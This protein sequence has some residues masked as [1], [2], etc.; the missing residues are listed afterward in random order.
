M[1]EKLKVG[2]SPHILD[3]RSVSSIM[4][5]VV[6]ALIP[7]TAAAIIYFGLNAVFILLVST[8]SAMIFESLVVHKSLKPK[9]VLGD[10][11]AA[12]T[13][14][15]LGLILPPSA[16]LWMAVVGSGVAILL[17]KQAFGGIGNNIFNP[18][19]VGR[20]VLFMSWPVLMT[21]WHQ[22]LALD[23]WFADLV[24]GATPLGAGSASL[25]DLVLGNVGGSLGETSVVAIL[26][27]GIYLLL[28][29]HIDWRIPGGYIGTAAIIALLTNQFSL[30][31]VAFHIC[32]GGLLFGAV[33]MATDMVTSPTTKVGRLLFGIGCGLVTMYVRVFA[34]APEGVTYAILF[35]NAL[36][37][38][39]DRYTVPKTFGEVKK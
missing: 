38:L 26:L 17:A 31:A 1:T 21:R 29:G 23:N 10:G 30:E 33:F 11:S 28:K 22:P 35:M 24:S 7:V 20:A 18:A 37:P 9:K 4:W 3:S 36:V 25:I 12:V 5:D 32:A 39:I 16:P 15:L 8:L 6:I 14:L 2:P 13:G 27:G 19:L 34:S